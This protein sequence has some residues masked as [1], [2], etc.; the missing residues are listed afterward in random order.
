MFCER[1]RLSLRMSEYICFLLHCLCGSDQFI[2]QLSFVSFH[3]VSFWFSHTHE[4][5]T[6]SFCNCVSFGCRLC[7]LFCLISFIRQAFLIQIK[8]VHF[9]WS[10]R[11]WLHF[12][13]LCVCV[14]ASR[15]GNWWNYLIWNRKQMQNDTWIL[16]SA[17]DIN[18]DF[19]S[20]HI[21]DILLH[22][23]AIEM[24]TAQ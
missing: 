11:R 6:H 14:F 8:R 23:E 24:C 18:L 20:Q 22:C 9:I 1:V 4:T 12:L 2:C 7:I 10:V 16:M 15:S 13:L 3:F 19:L 17:M 5:H 21:R